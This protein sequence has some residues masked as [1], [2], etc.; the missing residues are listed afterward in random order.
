MRLSVC[1]PPGPQS[2]AVAQLA[3]QLGFERIW[4]YDSAALFEDI[5]IH[6]ALAAE[7]TN[8][9]GLGTAVLVPSNR[10]VMTTASAI[11]T[12]ERLAPGRLVCAFGTGYTGRAVMAQKPVTWRAMT[13]Y[14]RQLKA[15][16]R[17]DTVDIDGKPCQ[18]IHH[19]AL[20]V[21]RPIEVPFV[22]SAFGPRGLAL[23]HELADG[24]MG[25]LPPPESETFDWAIQMV[26]GSVLLPG[27]T[28]HSERLLET[29]G[30]WL[31]G[32]YHASWEAGPDNLA[33]IPGGLEWLAQ[34]NSER[35][36]DQRHLSV[37]FGH[38]THLSS[39]GRQ[40]FAAMGDSKPWFGWVGD[41]EAVRERAR[42]SLAA[43]TTEIM[44]TPSGADLLG[45]IE[46]FYQALEPLLP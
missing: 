2:V 27:E 22:L 41:A 4:F 46:R 15:L 38:I 39:A 29:A 5:W 36:E 10:H 20:A 30:P 16:L 25:A 17:G 13:A 3:E 31:A 1:I 42:Q 23:T 7:A 11:A 21:A 32:M 9:L 18:M 34:V 37:H 12:I 28:L 8:T 26:P 44:Y 45:E 6:L 35:P 43:G 19:P 24:W 14:L 40:G 33:N